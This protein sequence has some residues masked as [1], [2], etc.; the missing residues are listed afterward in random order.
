MAAG[1]SKDWKLHAIFEPSGKQINS[2]G[3]SGASQGAFNDPSHS[4]VP[5]FA[6]NAKTRQSRARVMLT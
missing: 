3:T 5:F 2:L 4:H 6:G 1:A